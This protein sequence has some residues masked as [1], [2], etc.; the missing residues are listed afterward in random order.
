VSSGPADLAQAVLPL[1][2]ND[3]NAPDALGPT[4]RT[5]R[6]RRSRKRSTGA[7]AL[8]RARSARA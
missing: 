2:R 8:H 1:V 5:S 4:P 7:Q 6:L 3:S